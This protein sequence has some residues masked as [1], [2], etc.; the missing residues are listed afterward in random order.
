M[1][2][3]ELNKENY[4]Y[5]VNS[6]VKAFYP[7]EQV[8]ILIPE[9]REETRAMLRE[10]VN[11]RAEFYEDGA[12]VSIEGVSYKWNFDEG[13]GES[14][15]T[16]KDGFKRFFYRTLCQVTGRSL[17]WGN[18]I[19][20][21][22]VKI[23]YGLLEQGRSELDIVGH[24]MTKHYVSEEKARLS[25]D[26]AGRERELLS[27]IHYREGYS[28]YVGIPFCPT[29]CLYCSFTS[30]PIGGYRRMVDAYLDCLIKELA[31]V[32]KQCETRLLDTV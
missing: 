11:I 8:K 23:A 27:G 1:L 28:L 19:G 12:E 2:V 26:I 15:D 22:P 6:L 20:I 32:A 29:T 10:Q 14:G 31:Y 13:S 17:P 4:E 30:Y 21:R 25:V 7:Q 9:S 18:L 24:Y 16:Y 5:D 3:V